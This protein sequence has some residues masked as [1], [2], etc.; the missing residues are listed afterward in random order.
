[1]F[2]WSFDRVLP[3]RLSSVSTR[4]G[5]PTLAIAICT[6]LTSAFWYLTVYTTVLGVLAASILGFNV[7]LAVVAISGIAFPYTNKEIY[8][9]LDHQ[10]NHSWDSGDN[11][12]WLRGA[13]LPSLPDI[14]LLGLPWSLC[15]RRFFGNRRSDN[16]D[17]L[18]RYRSLL[19]RESLQKGQRGF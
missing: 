12:S 7:T 15:S 10:E 3:A 17:V 8:Q 4:F 6:V 2:A 18:A 19:R 1:M 16:R 11:S 9:K 13:R 14:R 5:T